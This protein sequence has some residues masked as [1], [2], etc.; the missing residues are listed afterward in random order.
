MRVVWVW[1]CC[2]WARGAWEL[3]LKRSS[4]L[5][6]R[7]AGDGPD[8]VKTAETDGATAVRSTGM[9]EPAAFDGRQQLTA[10]APDLTAVA[11]ESSAMFNF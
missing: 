10:P 3:R 8:T 6:V 9:C 7:S 4:H 1:G 5:P 2:V 11:L